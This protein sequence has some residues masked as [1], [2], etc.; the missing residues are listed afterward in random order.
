MKRTPLITLCLLLQFFSINLLKAQKQGNYWYFGSNAG[1]NFNTNPPTP[2]ENGMLNTSE[3]CATISDENGN[4]LFYTDGIRVYNKTHKVMSNG[5]NLTGNPSTSQSG[6][7]VPDPGNADKYYVFTVSAYG[8][9]NLSYSVVD[10]NLDGGLGNV[11]STKNVSVL[12]GTE[13]TVSAV[14]ANNFYW[15]L[16]HKKETDKYYAY[17]LTSTGLDI[18]NPVI[19][20]IGFKTAT[21]GDIG[22]LKSDVT[23]NRIVHTYYMGGK[24]EVMNFNKV[25][26]VLS[27][28]ISLTQASSYGVEFSP[29]GKVLYVHGYG[30]GTY[31][32]NLEAGSQTA[33]QNSKITLK[34]GVS[35]GALQVAV[36]G[37]IYVAN[38]GNNSLSVINN[39]N[40]VGSGC[41]YVYGGQSL[42]SKKSTIGLPTI[43]SSFVT[44]GPPI[45]SNP[46][47]SNVLNSSA[48]I[49]ATVN[50]DG[51]SAITE[52]GFYY[53]T[54]ANPTSNKTVVAGTTGSFN[55]NIDGLNPGTQYYFRGY[56]INANGTTY[57]V[58]ERFTTQSGPS[59]P[60]VVASYT[61][62]T[63][64]QCLAGNSYS[65]TNTSTTT[66]GTLKY[67]WSFGDGSVSAE[68]SPTHSY[69]ATGTYTVTLIVSEE[70]SEVEKIAT[71][72]VQLNVMPTAGFTINE[73]AQCLEGNRYSFS[74]TSGIG[75]GTISY[76]WDFGDGSVSSV[77]NPSHSYTT[78]G[79][80]TVKLI[81][82]SDNN[83][84]D[85]S[86][87]SVTVYPKPSVGFTVDN[88]AQCL[89]GNNYTF[90]NTSSISNGTLSYTWDFGDGTVVNT[91]NATHSYATAGSYTV[92]L[93]VASNNNCEEEMTRVVT[94]YEQPVAAFTIANTTQCFSDNRFTMTNTSSIASGNLRYEWTFGDGATSTSKD[95][96]HS[97]ASAGTYTIKLVVY[98]E[99]D[100]VA[101]A[102]SGVTV[103]PKP[104]VAFSIDNATQCLTGN[105]FSF[106]NTSS[107]ASGTITYEWIFGDGTVSSNESPRHQY[108]SPGT[109]QVKLIVRS[110]FNCV[111][112]ADRE[113]T[114][115]A[116]PTGS[117]SAPDGL[118]ICDGTTTL[119]ETSGGV[120]YQWF[121]DGEPIEGA[122]NARYEAG[123]GG[124]YTVEIFNEYDCSTKATNEI[125][126]THIKQPEADFSFDKYC[127]GIPTVFTNK[128]KKDNSGEVA[129]QWA[130]GSHTTS[131][132]ADPSYTFTQA[133]SNTITLVVTPSLCP[134]LSHTVSKN[135][136]AEVAPVGTRYKVIDATVGRDLTLKARELSASVTWSP[137]TNLSNASS[138]SPVLKPAREQDYKVQFDFESGCR[139][140]DTQ[141]VRI[142]KSDEIF[143]PKAFTPNGDGRNDLLKPMVVGIRQ[144]NY[145]RV[146]NRWGNLVF[147]TRAI[148]AGWDGRYKG[149]LQP[150][151]T[152]VWVAEGISEDGKTI[153]STGNTTLIR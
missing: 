44:T 148:G 125:I 126:L 92:K 36:N 71:K 139:T 146:Y 38:D 37:K 135:L 108:S 57:S 137:A 87:A 116:M 145:F 140:V 94:V 149:V 152:Y 11:T 49:N 51:G 43:M 98:S 65:F 121:V 81:V 72:S 132:S 67:S 73:I 12:T 122:T 134:E 29:N 63:A 32:F 96:S 75:S 46:T 138:F 10:M 23:G 89:D 76:A 64:N 129:Y 136:I 47:S 61:I 45:V 56:A 144:L 31:Q 8:N 24:T 118:T 70:D 86:T 114:V 112:S 16:T 55:S 100:C 103:Y 82:T 39:P 147:E 6:I 15:I 25:T 101:E 58:D 54:T 78:A 18:N 9:S 27:N 143:V 74:N 22:Y 141:M 66:S 50:G 69:A 109:Y 30:I 52:R 95:P 117:I 42:G 99:M 131:S 119:L 93:T 123:V 21:N 124:S 3:G 60:T 127:V 53:G 1:L 104:T 5:S 41:N 111:D 34:S 142:F 113:I 128:T 130:I 79:T 153:R 40:V 14:F 77:K 150:M 102:T 48:T 7:I 19:T 83:C 68:A 110:G 84:V 17:K 62:N 91:Q 133:G 59:L 35:E 105:E 20:S 107:I 106:S 80:Y 2:L 120:R 97:Y 88:L 4:L 28:L 151:E 115:Y 85:E 26:G 33:I 13:E 90:T